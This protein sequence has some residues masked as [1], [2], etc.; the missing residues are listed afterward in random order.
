MSKSGGKVE[1]R[2]AAR[3][4]KLYL[5][6]AKEMINQENLDELK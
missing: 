3:I 6:G 5:P 4:E 2:Y 1:E